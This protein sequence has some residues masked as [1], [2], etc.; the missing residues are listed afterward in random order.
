MSTRVGVG[1][2]TGTG[3]GAGTRVGMRVEVRRAW[4][5]NLPYLRKW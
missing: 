2:R 4:E 1:A 3:T 5:L